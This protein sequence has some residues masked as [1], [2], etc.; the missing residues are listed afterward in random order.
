MSD[1]VYEL[2]DW[3]SWE[4][5]GAP[6]RPPRIRITCDTELPFARS[7]L[8]TAC[9][10]P[11][12]IEFHAKDAQVVLLLTPMPQSKLRDLFEQSVKFF[13]PV[14]LTEVDFPNN[15]QRTWLASP[16]PKKRRA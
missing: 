3:E 4:I 11:E 6:G 9:L 10:G 5:P 13:L 8:L 2:Q 1:E 14:V 12:G 16:V 15:A 7:D